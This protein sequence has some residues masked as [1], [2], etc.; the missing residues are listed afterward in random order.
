M[1]YATLEPEA[2]GVASALSFG[3]RKKP[4]LSPI[5]CSTEAAAQFPVTWNALLPLVKLARASASDV[6]LA[7]SAM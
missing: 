2:T 3:R 7:P 6:A 1:E 5:S 4:A